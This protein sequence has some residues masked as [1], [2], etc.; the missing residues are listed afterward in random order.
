MFTTIEFDDHVVGEMW[1]ENGEQ[2][3]TDEP[4]RA[5]EDRR[6]ILQRVVILVKKRG[7]ERARFAPP[8]IESAKR[9]SR[10][11]ECGEMGDGFDR[12]VSAPRVRRNGGLGG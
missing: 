1:T 2:P 8:L 7:S 11:A 5:A 12:D 4:S 9:I 10:M 6:S 3:M